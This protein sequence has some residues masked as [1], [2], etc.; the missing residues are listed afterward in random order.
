MSEGKELQKKLFNQKKSGWENMN[1][2]YINAD[3]KIEYKD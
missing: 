1:E 2:D 3:T